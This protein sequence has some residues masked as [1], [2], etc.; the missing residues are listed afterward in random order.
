MGIK[1]K[2]IFTT[3]EKIDSIPIAYGQFICVTDTN[4]LYIDQSNTQRIQYVNADNID[5]SKLT[6]ML[7]LGEQSGIEIIAD[8][9][10]KVF[11]FNVLGLPTIKIDS[12][13]YWTI[14]GSRGEYPTKAQGEN[15]LTPHI[16]IN[17]KHWIIGTKDTGIF[18]E[19][20][21]GYSPKV[22][23]LKVENGVEITVSD[24]LGSQKALIKNGENGKDGSIT[25][26][27]SKID[28]S[29]VLLAENQ[30]SNLPYT[31]TVELAVIT[32]QLNPRVDI[33]VSDNIITGIKEEENF[34]YITRI[35][36]GDGVLIAQCYENK[37]SID[38]NLIIEVI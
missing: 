19:G 37:P 28:K 27:S 22:D 18:A 30:S 8:L 10:N 17:T 4:N 33:I 7:T 31:Y 21:D 1:F 34:N 15:G 9:D 32:S 24:Y 20:Q 35:T 25:I 38:L 29:T 12:E 5:F 6:D 26:S 13:G 23:L 2:P 3:Q 14:D 16:D 36:T 11:N